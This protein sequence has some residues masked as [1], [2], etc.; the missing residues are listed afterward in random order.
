[1]SIVD[2]IITPTL[3]WQ[4]SQPPFAAGANHPVLRESLHHPSHVF[5]FPGGP[6]L[7]PSH[8]FMSLSV[9]SVKVSLI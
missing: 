1:M 4:P 2:V 6:L 9:G 7:N 5:V 3:A 8:I